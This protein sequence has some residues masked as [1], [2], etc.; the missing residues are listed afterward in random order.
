MDRRSQIMEQ[1]ENLD[2][3]N[4]FIRRGDYF[5]VALLPDILSEGENVERIAKG[6]HLNVWGLLIATDRR[7]IFIGKNY[8]TLN[9]VNYGEWTYHEISSMTHQKGF[10]FGKIIIEVQGSRKEIHQ[11]PNSQARGF[12]EYVEN[13]STVPV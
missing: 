12:C 6:I 3:T 13:H 11:I 4:A 9:D 5:L 1:V 2:G 10:I 7:V 8:N